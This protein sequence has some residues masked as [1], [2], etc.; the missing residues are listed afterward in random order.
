MKKIYNWPL[1][2]AKLVH[3]IKEIPTP[4]KF[5]GMIEGYHF[6]KTWHGEYAVKDENSPES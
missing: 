3:D 1:G 5:I 4:H 2:S 6:Y